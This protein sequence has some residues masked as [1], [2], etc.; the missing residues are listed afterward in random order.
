MPEHPFNRP[1]RKS[2]KRDASSLLLASLLAGLLAGC[3]VGPDYHPPETQVP[4]AWQQAVSQDLKGEQPK[5]VEWWTLFNDPLL[6]SLITR[7]ATNN[8]DLRIA[9]ARLD[10][11][12]ALRGAAKS[13][14]LPQVDANAS[15]QYQRYSKDTK[16][17]PVNGRRETGFYSVGASA[18]WELDVWGRVRRLMEAADADLQASLEDY[19]DTLVILCAEVATT[20]VNVRTLQ[21]RI[22]YAE[23]N[24]VAQASTL[25]LTRDLND[26]GLVGDLDISQAQLNLARTRSVIPAYRTALVQAINR[27]GVLL[28]EPPNALHEELGKSQPIPVPPEAILA[29]VPADL[30]RQ[31]PDIRRA[32]RWLAA[33]TA[34]IGVATAELYPQFSLPG[35]LALEAFDPGNLDGSSLT[36]AFGPTVRWSLF[37]GGRI[38]NTIRA[39][40]ARTR[41]MLHNY[42]QTVLLALEDVENAMVAVAQ[43]RDRKTIVEQARK[44]ARTS[45]R[46]VKDLYRNGLTDFQNVLDM[47]RS[48]AVEEDNLAVSRGSLAANAV[49]VYRALGGGWDPAAPPPNGLEISEAAPIPVTDR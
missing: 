17:N 46:L 14:L 43:E 37:S 1:P 21:E 45:V 48:L 8:L 20:Y 2:V 28:G 44:A 15:A 39:E 4:D 18:S 47:E 34:R 49:S 27:L 6:D 3:M 13:G 9:V 11:A 32:E 23:S 22:R 31:R 38:R 7:A 12:M 29:G 35:T 19:R 30:L 25:K 26:A 16:P 41:Q 42:E 24:A 36:Y 40:E 10:E 33:Q 5:L